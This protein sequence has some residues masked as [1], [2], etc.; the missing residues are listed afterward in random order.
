MTT[1]LIF[2]SSLPLG[3]RHNYPC[4]PQ[5]HYEGE[6]NT[7]G[8]IHQNGKAPHRQALRV[9]R[10]YPGSPTSHQQAE[11]RTDAEG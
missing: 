9:C 4:L 3:R 11:L 5:P 10:N 7:E 2:I 8:E 1:L 6:R